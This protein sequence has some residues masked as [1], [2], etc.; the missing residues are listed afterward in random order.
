MKKLPW[1]S[2][3]FWNRAPAS[4]IPY[5]LL[6]KEPPVTAM[7]DRLLRHGHILKCGRLS[8]GQ[9]QT[10][11][12]REN[13]DKNNQVPGRVCWPMF[14]TDFELGGKVMTFAKTT[15]MFIFLFAWT[16]MPAASAAPRSSETAFETF[17]GF[18]G[19]WAIRSGQKT[20]PIEMTY[21]I[22]SKGSIVTE[23]FGKELSVFYR[24]GQ[25][26]LMTHYCNGG[27]QPR[28]RLKES[29]RPG[30]FEFEMFDITGLKSADADHV[31]RVIYRII[32]DKTMDLEIIWEKGKS[33]ESEKYTLT[34]LKPEHHVG[35]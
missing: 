14:L 11:P 30:V 35:S 24:D 1:A 21:E 8:C 27:N 18:D 32:D 5:W 16:L 33:E 10:C 9:K 23:Q 12:V 13:P 20:L 17:K 26:L 25:S 22:G 31:Q 19:K 2:W 28:L 4:P 29:G 15:T 7:L 3:K 6:L 34:R